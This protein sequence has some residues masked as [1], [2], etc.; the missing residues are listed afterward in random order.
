MYV[1]ITSEKVGV[2]LSAF[3]YEFI[4]K[5]SQIFILVTIMIKH[6]LVRL[7][8][9]RSWFGWSYIDV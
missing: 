9:H 5:Y 6:D 8:P 4:L 2:E 7:T 1:K 3:M